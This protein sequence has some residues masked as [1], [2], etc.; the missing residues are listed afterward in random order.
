[1]I[2]TGIGHPLPSG[3]RAIDYS[4]VSASMFLSLREVTN[5]PRL[6]I[7][8]C[9]QLAQVCKGYN[10]T[11]SMFMRSKEESELVV[12]DALLSGSMEGKCSSSGS[13]GLA[14]AYSEQLVVFDSLGYYLDDSLLLYNQ[15]PF[16]F[17]PVSLAYTT[18]CT[19]L[20]KM[21]RRW[22]LFPNI[23]S[24]H[25]ACSCHPKDVADETIQDCTNYIKSRNRG[26]HLYALIQLPKKMHPSFDPVIAG[27]LAA[28]PKSV[29]LL[30]HQTL[31]LMPRWLTTLQQ[32]A[33]T[34]WTRL[35]FVPR[36]D[37]AEYLQLLSLASVFLNTF[38]FGAGVTSS[39]ALAVCVPVVSLPRAS[40]VLSITLAQIK[41]LGP[42]A[43]DWL[44]EDTD[45]YITKAVAL[46]QLDDDVVV[47]TEMPL[48]RL[49]EYRRRICDEKHKLFGFATLNKAI[50]EWT[51]FLFT[52]GKETWRNI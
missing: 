32:S 9:V 29:I 42:I 22:G 50:Q 26:R 34:L 31:S 33:E 11:N 41:S 4:I 24:K 25:L 28:D 40:S 37:H 6:N 10:S 17:D 49:A 43:E 13:A 1:M 8:E 5:S 3:S 47:G 38:P 30:H 20:D 48:T 16:P 14:G 45:A 19:E 18:P 2:S 7:T 35:V 52:F 21:F 23:S 46:A 27:I 12:C 15:P 36:L 39:E 51:S 44:V